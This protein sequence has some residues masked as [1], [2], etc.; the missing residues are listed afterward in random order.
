[1]RRYRLDPLEQ[2]IV[3]TRRAACLPGKKRTAPDL[4]S[5]CRIDISISGLAPVRGEDCAP[6]NATRA[7][8]T[9]KSSAA[10]HPFEIPDRFALHE[11]AKRT[12]RKPTTTGDNGHSLTRGWYCRNR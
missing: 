8:G 6:A 5:I 12:G 7:L 4:F 3:G 10:G 11:Q 1:M 2:T 9:R